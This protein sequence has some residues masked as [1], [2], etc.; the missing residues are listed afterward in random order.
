L[1]RS[2][3]LYLILLLPA[4]VLAFFAFRAA[5]QDY[6]EGLARLRARLEEEA[7][8]LGRRVEGAI[9]DAARRAEESLRAAG[10]P[11]AAGERGDGE[12]IGYSR[13]GAWLGTSRETIPAEEALASSAEERRFY[14]LSRAGG[15]SYEFALRDPARAVDA[16]SFYLPRLRSPVLRERLR[17]QM[18]RA[19]LKGGDPA[20]GVALLGEII[21]RPGGG[22]TPDGLPL[23]LLAA[24]R[25]EDLVR[26][27]GE[28]P[29]SGDELRL[30]L[31]R[32]AGRLPL[33]LLAKVVRERFPRDAAL[34]RLLDAR[35]SL[36]EAVRRH[37]EILR[38][39]DAALDDGC[40]LLARALDGKDRSGPPVRAIRREPV[41][42]PP[43]EA[44]SFQARI[45]Y[46]PARSVS[47]KVPEGKAAGAA[48]RP[49][50]IGEN[51]MDLAT[52][53][54]WD[55]AGQEG[56]RALA[57]RRRL[58]KS[59]V[60]LLVLMTLGG[61]AAL[62]RYLA[63]ERHLAALRA[64]L[65]ANVSHELKTPV[66]S[67]R[68]FSE[69]LA[70]DPLDEAR[71]RRFGQLL[72]SESLRLS[73]LIESLLDFSRLRKKDESVHPEPVDLEALLER[74][75]EGFS[76][77][78]RE[79]GVRFTVE[80]GAS[81]R[82]HSNAAA[83]ERIL[84]NLL[85]NALKYRRREG[86]WVALKAER[87]DDRLLLSVSDNG[88]G[89][90]RR[91]RERV[92]E[93]FYRVRYDDYAVQGSGLGLAIARRLARKL[94]GEVTLESREGAGSTFTLSL[95]CGEDA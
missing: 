58:Q 89:I 26:E 66:T 5:D 18:A 8:A 2:L 3:V 44:G 25:L 54:V 62:L 45:E 53:L 68:M 83:V 31:S 4:G 43:L 92:F 60:G 77:R 69:M 57:W 79:A 46:P 61:G 47:P 95:P 15:E 23:D 1:T 90:P 78:A 29:G 52:L 73:V 35:R 7:E 76:F 10:A 51:G 37:P 56:L 14:E 65:L 19:A 27:G 11:G 13:D 24:L 80:N 41:E 32:N 72:R 36:E 39:R 75:G 17:F 48:L 63:R 38:D 81:L 59:L 70:E 71:T 16:Y 74:V 87:S 12:L 50:R 20:L 42:L 33:A 93:E 88:I 40:L 6:G 55:P 22:T 34:S 30:S 91:E 21:A 9:A 28:A 49:V 86:P 82:F 85:D 64:R 94:G 67:I 84:Q